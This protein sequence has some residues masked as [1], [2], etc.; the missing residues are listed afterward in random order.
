MRNDFEAE[1]I[2]FETMVNVFLHG[3]S[4]DIIPLHKPFENPCKREG[5]YLIIAKNK[6]GSGFQITGD[7]KGNITNI[8]AFDAEGNDIRR[9]YNEGF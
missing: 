4:M 8:Q 6:N 5:K 9:M 3:R 7:Y 2:H 1:R